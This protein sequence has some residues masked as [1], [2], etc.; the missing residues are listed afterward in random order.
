VT[1]VPY[2]ARGKQ[3]EP[4]RDFCEATFPEAKQDLA[5]VFL[6]RCLEFCSTGVAASTVLPQNWLFLSS[7]ARPFK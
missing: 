2:L 3:D 6:E 1:N 7:Y 5:I 4:L